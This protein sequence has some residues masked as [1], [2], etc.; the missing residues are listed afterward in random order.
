VNTLKAVLLI[1]VTPTRE[2]I[3]A[4]QLIEEIPEITD[5]WAVFGE[6]DVVA[7]IETDKIET[8]SKIITNRIR[9]MKGIIKTATLISVPE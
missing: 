5:A 7:M 4:K 2:K 3:V 1:R 8:M 6:Y 9:N